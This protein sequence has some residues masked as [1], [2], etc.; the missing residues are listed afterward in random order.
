MHS[1]ETNN[2]INSW[3]IA[4][5]TVVNSACCTVRRKWITVRGVQGITVHCTVVN[6]ALYR[7]QLYTVHCT[8]QG[9]TGCCKLDNSACCTVDNSALYS[10]LYMG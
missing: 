1:T 10:V 7:G 4:Y 6:C 8:V 3:V 5:C 9:I 2:E